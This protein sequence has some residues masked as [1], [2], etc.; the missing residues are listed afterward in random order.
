M[1]VIDE[2]GYRELLTE[3]KA[4]LVNK[5]ANSSGGGVSNATQTDDGLMSA[6]DKIKLDGLE[7]SINPTETFVYAG[8][9]TFTLQHEPSSFTA[10]ITILR[11]TDYFI[12]NAEYTLA[13]RALTIITP[14][15]NGD[16]VSVFYLHATPNINNANNAAN[17]GGVP[18]QN[19]VQEAKLAN[20]VTFYSKNILPAG[21]NP[22]YIAARSAVNVDPPTEFNDFRLYGSGFD[23]AIKQAFLIMCPISMQIRNYSGS[24]AHNLTD[25]F[26]SLDPN[27][28][29][30]VSF[31][32]T[33][34]EFNY[35]TVRGAGVTT[36]I[37]IGGDNDTGI[38]WYLYNPEAYT[39]EAII[40]YSLLGM[41]AGGV[42]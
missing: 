22:G 39:Q 6:E 24:I 38:D 25:L 11:G 37:T 17:L 13:G 26:P 36:R 30:W 4:W 16:I 10:P 42:V 12:P 34:E 32:V 20:W 18:A 35:I 3:L 29:E 23:D 40:M 8:N 9:P 15:T 27:S 14:L 5:L 7:N 1:K 2:N 19:F 41:I 28:P 31:T 21:G 33:Q